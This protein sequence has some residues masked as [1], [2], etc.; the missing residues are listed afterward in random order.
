MSIHVCA[1]GFSIIKSCTYWNCSTLQAF[2]EHAYLFYE[3]CNLHSVSKM[4]GVITINGAD[5]KIKY[6]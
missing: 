3:K 6:S 5:I 1:I 2:H 4:P